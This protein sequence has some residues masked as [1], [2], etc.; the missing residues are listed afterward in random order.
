[1]DKA[2][3]DARNQCLNK[4]GTLWSGP[5]AMDDACWL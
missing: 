5:S 1:M 2:H 4:K 3:G